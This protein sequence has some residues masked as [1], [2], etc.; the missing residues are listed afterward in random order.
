MNLRIGR[1]EAVIVAVML[2]VL[3]LLIFWFIGYKPAVTEVNRLRQQQMEISKKI[4]EN[5][6]TLQR[7]EE[8]RKESS[9]VEAQMV[10]IL[11]NLPTKP[12]IASYVI[13]M[14]DV[15]S[16]CGVKIDSF[17]PQM[18]AQDADYARIPVDLTI[19]AYFNEIPENG[20][21]L[22]EFLYRL[23]KLPRVT[24]VEAINLVR[25]SD[26]EAKLVVTLKLNTYSLLSSISPKV[27]T[28]TA[29]QAAQQGQQPATTQ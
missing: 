25:Q 5:T 26:S 11:S 7:L 6:L 3:E 17:K 20:G 19:S 13:M 22:I 21:S 2:L 14:N 4:Q 8:L 12:E 27:T 1:Q 24:N 16:R 23:E 15:A 29:P 18:P 9:K 10:Q 28:Q